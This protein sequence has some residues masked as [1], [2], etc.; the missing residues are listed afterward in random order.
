MTV[1][2]LY[3][4]QNYNGNVAVTPIQSNLNKIE[5]L[6]KYHTFFP[7][8]WL[9]PSQKKKEYYKIISYCTPPTYFELF[10]NKTSIA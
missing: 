4:W 9:P 10:K 3:L 7:W 6:E 2:V 1:I 8:E 5:F